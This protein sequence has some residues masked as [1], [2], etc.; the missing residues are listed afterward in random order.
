[1]KQTAYLINT[2]RGGVVDQVALR[3]ALAAGEIAGAGPR[4][5]RARAAP[6]G[7]PAAH[8]A[9]PARRAACRQRHHPHP[10]ADGGHGRRQPARRARREGDAA[11]GVVT[12]VAAVDIGTNSTRLL[13]ADR[14]R[15]ARARLDRH[16]P[17]RGRRLAAAGSATPPSS[18]CST[19]CARFRAE[20]ADARL[21]A[22]RRGDDLGRPRRRQ[23]PR[24][25]RAGPG[26]ARLRPA[27]PQRRRGGPAHLRRGDA[28]PR[29]AS[30]SS[31]TSAAARPSSSPRVR[32]SRPR[33]AS[34]GTRERHLHSDPPTAAE[35]ANLTRDV[36]E[37]LMA[38]VPVR[39]HEKPVRCDRGRR[40]ADPVRGDRPRPATTTTQ[41]A[42]KAT[43]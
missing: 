28:R 43:S 33:S 38:H 22:R 20:I 3:E 7:R 17:R 31:S 16:P 40:H 19:S 26:R 9:Q 42:S 32:T 39:M 41:P 4:R 13:I 25:R 14:R 11:P 24:V 35:L 2:A 6:E 8:G 37:T 18:A 1:M 10:L 36:H 27:H 12:R 23:R 34:S 5:H 29:P 21:R 15:R 30:S